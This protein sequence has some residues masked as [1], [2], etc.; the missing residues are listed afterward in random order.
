M[1]TIYYRRKTL[2]D[3]QIKDRETMENIII[4]T[5]KDILSAEKCSMVWKGT[6]TDL[7]ELLWITYNKGNLMEADGSMVTYKSM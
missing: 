6:K 4:E 2:A 7:L 3:P 1:N 5:M